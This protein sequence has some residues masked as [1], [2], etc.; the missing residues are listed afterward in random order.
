MTESITPTCTTS[1]ANK[2]TT[3]DDNGGGGDNGGGD[4]ELSQPPESKSQKTKLASGGGRSGVLWAR[5]RE[6]ILRPDQACDQSSDPSPPPNLTGAAAKPSALIRARGTAIRSVAS[7]GEAQ[8]LVAAIHK[9]DGMGCWVAKIAHKLCVCGVYHICVC[10]VWFEG[11]QTHF[12]NRVGMISYTSDFCR[13]ARPRLEKLQGVT[14]RLKTVV[15]FITNATKSLKRHQNEMRSETHT[16]GDSEGGGAAGA[17]GAVRAL[18]GA[19]AARSAD[20]EALKGMWYKANTRQWAGT[21]MAGP[22][23][24]TSSTPGTNSTNGTPGTPGTPRNAVFPSMSILKHLP[25]GT[26]PE[27]FHK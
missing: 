13:R 9:C 18:L 11:E 23:A 27:G 8:R 10:F 6:E 12:S 7:S 4:G 14:G 25:P 3:G 22:P 24:C 20:A 15:M 1:D 26:T 19:K 17:A 21:V 16:V 5:L 2:R